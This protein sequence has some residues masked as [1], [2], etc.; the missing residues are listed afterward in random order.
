M[1]SEVLIKDRIT[2]NTARVVDGK[3]YV[4]AII[5]EVKVTTSNAS[6]GVSVGSTTTTVL[7]VNASRHAAIIVNDS[8][9]AI[10][11]KYG[12][13]AELNKGIR[14]NAYG[15]SIVETMYTGIITGI[16]TSGSKVVTVTEL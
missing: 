12:S 14:L 3:L 2:G 15:G 1:A 5:D 9:E 4:D 7:A 11:L 16:C 6:V 13:G 10:Y 8:D